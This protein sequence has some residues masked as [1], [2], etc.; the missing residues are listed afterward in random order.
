MLEFFH[1]LSTDFIQWGGIKTLILPFL[2]SWVLF[3]FFFLHK[4]LFSS[5]TVW[6]QSKFCLSM[7]DLNGTSLSTFTQPKMPQY[8][9][10]KPWMALMKSLCNIVIIQFNT[11]I[12]LKQKYLSLSHWN[13]HTGASSH[14]NSFLSKL[15]DVYAHTYT[16]TVNTQCFSINTSWMGEGEGALRLYS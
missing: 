10:I 8:P 12:A 9:N 11:P 4:S 15:K 1:T 6:R 5:Y 16:H 7:A 13:R 3:F 14:G 2:M